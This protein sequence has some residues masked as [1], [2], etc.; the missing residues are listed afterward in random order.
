MKISKRERFENK[1][2]IKLFIY[3]FRNDK[4]NAANNL[5]DTEG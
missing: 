3:F 5:L 2:T 1:L 4:A